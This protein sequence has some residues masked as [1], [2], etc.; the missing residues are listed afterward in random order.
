MRL[1]SRGVVIGAVIALCTGCGDNASDPSSVASCG[2]GIVDPGETCDDENRSSGDGCS[3]DCSSTE[4][5]GNGIVDLGEACDCGDGSSSPPPPCGETLNGGVICTLGCTR[6]GCGNAVAD[7]FEVCD[8]GNTVAGDGCSADCGSLEVCGNG[9][10]DGASQEHCD[11]GNQVDG[12][13]CSADCSSLEVCGNQIVDAAPGEKCDD[14][15]QLDGDGCGADCRSLEVCGNQIVDAAAGEQCDEG[16]FGLSGEGCSSTCQ[17][18]S[19]VWTNFTPVPFEARWGHAVAYDATRHVIVMFGGATSAGVTAETWEW[20]A[21]NWT[22]RI[23]ASSPTARRGHSLIYDKAR[24]RTLLFGGLDEN[25]DYLADAWEWDGTSWTQKSFTGGPGARTSHAM[26]YD[27][28]KQLGVLFGGIG[29]VSGGG[30]TLLDDTWEWD[31]QSWTQKSPATVPWWSSYPLMAYAG[32]AGVMMYVGSGTWRWNG[33]NWTRLSSATVSG[34]AT[35][36]VYDST[37]DQPLLVGTQPTTG[38]G[39]QVVYSWNGSQWSSIGYQFGPPHRDYAAIEFSPDGNSILMNGG[40]RDYGSLDG[41]ELYDD[42]WQFMGG[43]WHEWHGSAPP[44]RFGAGLVD[45]VLRGRVLMFGGNA[46]DGSFLVDT[47]EWDGAT[48][49]E[50]HPTTAPPR[51]YGFGMEYDRARDRTVLFGGWDVTCTSPS[52]CQYT[53]LNDTWEWDGSEWTQVFPAQSPPASKHRVYRAYTARLNRVIAVVS[54]T[55]WAWD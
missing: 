9:I 28:A 43:S 15:N 55:R 29:P 31:G 11:D 46:T 33:A 36:L 53:F 20:S 18:E 21:G 32:T 4:T 1:L 8:D 49:I 16:L 27:P 5:C 14:G 41:P 40:Q 52:N 12:D 38:Y 50:R 2:D 45:Q 51:R 44:G 13:G 47:W 30:Y 17:S 7:P 37:N 48:W 26:A 6:A 10:L 23:P 34:G 35:K 3:N 25:G 42:T 39:I 22:R 24:S 19:I 54:L